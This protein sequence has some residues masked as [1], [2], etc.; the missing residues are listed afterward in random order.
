MAGIYI[1]IPY[2][3]QAC[4]YCDFHFSTNLK[5]KPDLIGA[6]CSEIKLRDNYLSSNKINTIYFGGGTP[7]M[8]TSPELEAI[9]RAVY[10]QF[11]VSGKAEITLEAN[12]DDLS[13]EN[14]KNFRSQGINRLS[15][16]IQSFN[17]SFLKKFNRAHTADMAKEAVDKARIAKFDNI[18]VDLIFGIPDQSLSEFKDDLQKVIGLNPEHVSIYGL[19]IEENTVFGKWEK[20]KKL[21]PID[22]EIAAQQFELIMDYLP[23]AGF[24]QYEVSNFCRE[25]YESRHNSSYWDGKEYLGV[26]PSAHSFNGKTRQYNITNNM[27]YIHSIAKGEIPCEVEVLSKTDR[28]NEYILTKI[29]T[30]PGIC[31]EEMKSRFGFN[32]EKIYEEKIKYYRNTGLILTN[33]RLVL[34]KAGR[35]VAD[36]ITA[37]FIS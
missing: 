16:G 20:S 18:S 26:G 5:T 28:I 31:F 6:I 9:L 36:A 10:E 8:L 15:I 3:K 37:S 25:G 29:R 24:R 11:E 1:H 19:T 23:E 21:K 35:L 30:E 13:D 17:D 14:L 34:T 4:H 7:S 12:P 22:E 27:K 33:D 2:C 32:F